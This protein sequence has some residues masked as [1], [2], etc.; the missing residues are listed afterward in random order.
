MISFWWFVLFIAITQ[1]I[2]N[3]VL[4]GS[5]RVLLEYE[6]T[7][8][9]FFQSVVLVGFIKGLHGFHWVKKAYFQF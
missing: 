2:T 3:F 1:N 5:F 8:Y 7:F 9:Y 6:R 4:I